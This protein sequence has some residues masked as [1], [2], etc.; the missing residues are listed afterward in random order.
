MKKTI[1]TLLV[2]A[3]AT[4]FV[5][6]SFTTGEKEPQNM[7][8]SKS[9]VGIWRQLNFKGQM[10]G[11]YKFVNPDGTFYSMVVFGAFKP[12][13]IMMYG[14]Y[15]ITSDST[16]TE[17]IIGHTK[18]FLRNTDSKLKYKL[19]DENTLLIQYKNTEIDRWIPEK[20]VRV[21]MIELQDKKKDNIEM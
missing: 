6:S 10:T 19:L 11:N 12:S 8:V 1:L 16:Y 7:A 4:I 3:M 2:V 15:K 21:P 13:M 9:F 20:W 17:H 5:C 18:S 14:N